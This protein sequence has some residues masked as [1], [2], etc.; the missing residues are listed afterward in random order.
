MQHR[1]QQ[2]L[3]RDRARRGTRVLAPNRAWSAL[4]VS[5]GLQGADAPT[6]RTTASGTALGNVP[7]TAAH[8][9]LAPGC[10]VYGTLV[11]ERQHQVLVRWQGL[12][13][14]SCVGRHLCQLL[15]GLRGV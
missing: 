6:L 15:H 7:S 11:S 4:R 12:G 5:G 9:K 2:C 3:C 1:N 10:R 8:D 14:C 13:G